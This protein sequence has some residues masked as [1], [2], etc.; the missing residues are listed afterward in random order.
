MASETNTNESIQSMHA[1]RYRSCGRLVSEECLTPHHGSWKMLHCPYC[2][3]SSLIYV[4][5]AKGEESVSE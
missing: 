4:P 3:R 1:C 2:K 5:A